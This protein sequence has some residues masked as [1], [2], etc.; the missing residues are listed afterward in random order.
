[1]RR[2]FPPAPSQR[3]QHQKAARLRHAEQ[4]VAEAEREQREREESAQRERAERDRRDRQVRQRAHEV[5][6]RL[7]TARR[8]AEDAQTDLEGACAQLAAGTATVEQVE[9]YQR[10]RDASRRELELLELAAADLGAEPAIVG[11]R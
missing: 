5:G 4:A 1:V 10:E 7:T 11:R 3:A 9:P 2:T 8:A 6:Q